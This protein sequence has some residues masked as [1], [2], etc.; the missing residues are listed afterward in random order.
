MSYWHSLDFLEPEMLKV[1]V[2]TKVKVLSIVNKFLVISLFIEL[3]FIQNIFSWFADYS[4]FQ[5]KRGSFLE[6]E[7]YFMHLGKKSEEVVYPQCHNTY[8]Y[9]NRIFVCVSNLFG[10]IFDYSTI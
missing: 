4:N 6:S 8:A 2:F 5:N 7:R 1:I 9:K 10:C 3:C